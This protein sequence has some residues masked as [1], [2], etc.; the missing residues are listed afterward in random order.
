MLEDL[1][2]SRELENYVSNHND[3]VTLNRKLKQLLD[4]EIGGMD[5][6]L[7]KSLQDSRKYIDSI[8]NGRKD[9]YD[10]LLK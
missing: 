10:D 1:A 8:T 6:D 2:Q 3:W 5:F 9:E 4:E 7:Q